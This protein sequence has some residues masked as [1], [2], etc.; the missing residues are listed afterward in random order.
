M[1][2]IIPTGFAQVVIEHSV[3]GNTHKPTNVFGIAESGSGAAADLS[4][5]LSAWTSNIM[6]VLCFGLTCRVATLVDGDGNLATETANVAGSVTED[7]CPPNVAALVKKVT[8]VAG[9]INQGRF[10]LAGIRE[11]NVSDAGALTITLLENLQDAVNGF[12]SDLGADSVDLVVLHNDAL[13]PTPTLVTSL[14]VQEL[15]ATQ[16]RRLR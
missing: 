4:T 10:Y 1:P 15:V 6:P 13:T 9:R 2:V 8:N 7:M 11:D 16:R 5:V 3:D 14:I 12:M